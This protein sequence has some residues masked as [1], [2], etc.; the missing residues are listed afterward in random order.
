MNYKVRALNI[1]TKEEGLIEFKK[2]GADATGRNIMVNKIQNFA[3]KIKDIDTRA[4]NILKQEMLSRGGDV[5]TSREA[6]YGN[7]G[8]TD[9]IILGTR[10]SIKSLIE[11]IKIQQFGLKKLS[12]DLNCYIDRLGEEKKKK[13]LKIGGRE[14]NLKNEVLVMGVLNVTPDSFYDGGYYF[15]KDKAYRRVDGIVRQGAQIID[16]GG[17]SSRPGSLPVNLD[18]EM[19]RTIPVIKHTAKNYDILI[20]IDTYHSKVAEEAVDAGAHII[21]DISGLTLDKN[22]AGIAAESKSSV[23]IMHMKGTPENMQKNPEYGDV[24]DEIYNYLYDRTNKAL[25]TGISE[26]RI[27]VDPGI[28]F[29]KTLRH[30]LIILDKLSEFKSLGYPVLVGTSRK[31]FI[32]NILDLPEQERLE[33]SLAAAVCS[34]INGVNILRV[35]DVKETIRAIKI[36]MS[37]I[38]SHC[39]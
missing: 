21:N 15:K 9:I 25:E 12:D 17:M 30:N 7:G 10:K 29:G 1:K 34:V 6:L 11:K 23:I 22:M 38:G 32:G 13:I 31:S 36:A 3:L 27:I 39:C 20:S 16:V 5:V 4:A 26:D 18:E 28:G 2:I 35:H 24:V 8:K 33:G 37:I 14:F 19:D